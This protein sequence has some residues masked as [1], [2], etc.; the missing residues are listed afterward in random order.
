[1]SRTA[2]E[3]R[4]AA[5]AGDGGDDR[6]RAKPRTPLSL[7][8]KLAVTAVGAMVLVGV[9]VALVAVLGRPRLVVSSQG[10][11]LFTVHAGGIGS[12]LG[13]VR[14][15][16]VGRPLALRRAD[17][18]FVPVDRVAQGQAIQVRAEV[19][20]PSWLRWLVGGTVT[21]AVTLHAPV[22]IPTA[23]VVIARGAGEA[24]V[25]F[26]APVS[27]VAYAQAGGGTEVVHLAKATDLVDL[28]VRGGLGGSL[29][30]EAA[31]RPWERLSARPR[32]LWWF[33]P[34][35]SGEPVALAD[36]APGSATAKS[37][38]RISLTFAGPVS[39]VLGTSRPTLSPA[40][41]GTWSQ[42]APNQLVF[43]PSG[44]GFGPGTSVAVR[45]GRPIAVAAAT[46][47]EQGAAIT[48]AATS[49]YTFQVAPGSL[50]R[51]AQ[52]LAQLHYLPLR[53][54]PA[55]GVA[56]PITVAQEISTISAPLPGSFS[57]RWAAIPATL[58]AQWTPSTFDNVLVK[59]A[60]MAFDANRP[61]YAYDGYTLDAETV[62]QMADA[63]TWEALIEAAV[64][65]RFD[66][67]PYSYVY[68]SKALPETLTL[69]ENGA[70]VLTSLT[71][72]GIP[73]DPT[74][75]GTFP[76]YVRY[77]VNYMNGT[78][79]TGSTY[80]DLVYWINYFN[81]GDAVHGFVRAAYG[82]PQSL[83]CVELPI[84][85]AQTVFGDLAIGDLVTVSG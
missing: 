76:I 13:P 16:S 50:A 10:E 72:T 47:P 73:Q 41:P 29:R 8:T 53:F 40:V 82:F 79:P 52:L 17:G 36:P 14:A 45:F 42:P 85:T 11:A 68:V 54:V 33:S 37:N 4:P 77:T 65:H 6:A 55:P 74:V 34:P 30:V 71:N 12:R 62:S 18:G 2:P 39:K 84:P 67:N 5:S 31:P 75:D 22:A 48:A 3:T 49:T 63:S 60:L 44:F 9:V 7:A 28:S 69:W 15:T 83:G 80:H 26:D 81:G 19:S 66:P 38:T 21:A 70:D 64:A 1:M 25:R 24:P 59:G 78:N 57:W 32:T 51:L 61:T 46:A 58:A 35:A 56:L 20:P 27:T 23:S 43:T